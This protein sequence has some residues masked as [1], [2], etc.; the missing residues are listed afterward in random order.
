MKNRLFKFR[1]KN[2]FLVKFRGKI[3]FTKK[4]KK[5]KKEGYVQKHEIANYGKIIR[6]SWWTSDV[7]HHF[8]K[9]L[10]PI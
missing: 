6:F 7:V 2:K 8:S 1:D 3:V 4:E 5:K 9:K 10:S